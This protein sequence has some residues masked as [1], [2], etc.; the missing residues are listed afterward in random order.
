MTIYSGSSGK[1]NKLKGACRAMSMTALERD[2]YAEK[3][4]PG[5]IFIRADNG[6]V[7]L[8]DGVTTLGE[9][10]PLHLPAS[11][12]DGGNVITATYAT[13]TEL[14]NHETSLKEWCYGV[15]S[16]M[17][18]DIF[19]PRSVTRTISVGAWVD[20][21][22]V[23]DIGVGEDYTINLTLPNEASTA[24]MMNVAMAG[25]YVVS[26]IGTA[27]TL[28]CLNSEPTED[29]RLVFSVFGQEQDATINGDVTSVNDIEI[30]ETTT[31]EL[32]EL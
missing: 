25:I 19:K 11:V 20:N 24:N 30:Q 22:V 7:F 32:D 4:F 5:N 9:L 8:T 10:E 3:V 2:T 1:M 14:S 28:K 26:H 12:D 27:I 23:V 13:K 18:V 17:C 6:E 31:A 29:I 15:I 16:T 21:T